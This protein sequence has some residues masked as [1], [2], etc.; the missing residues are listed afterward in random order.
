MEYASVRFFYTFRTKLTNA[1][2]NPDASPTR[3][4]VLIFLKR[5]EQQQKR[6]RKKSIPK[7]VFE[8]K[9]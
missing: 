4:E 6:H 8:S 2:M 9:L 5:I 1:L 7:S 3:E